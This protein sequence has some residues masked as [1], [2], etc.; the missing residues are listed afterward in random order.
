MPPYGHHERLSAKTIRYRAL[1]GATGG[2]TPMRRQRLRPAPL[3]RGVYLGLFALAL[4]PEE[5]AT[6]AATASLKPR[7]SLKQST[8]KSKVARS[9]DKCNYQSL[10]NHDTAAIFDYYITIPA[11][12]YHM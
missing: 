11:V 7:P 2:C 3:S 1:Q 8:L 10:L 6:V 4:I 9:S 5:I 12:K